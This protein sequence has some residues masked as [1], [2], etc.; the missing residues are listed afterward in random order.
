MLNAVW[1]RVGISSKRVESM[2]HAF[3]VIDVSQEVQTTAGIC[4]KVK[5]SKY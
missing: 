2:S 1:Q 5:T 3:I 4:A